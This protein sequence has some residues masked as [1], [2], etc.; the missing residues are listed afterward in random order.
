MIPERFVVEYPQRCME[1]LDMS[2]GLARER[3]LLGSFSLIMASSLLLIPYERMKKAHP[4]G[5]AVREPEIYSAIRSVERKRFLQTDFW[6]EVPPGEWR[7]SRILNDVNQTDR[8]QDA[9]R[10][11]PMDKDAVNGINDRDTGGIIRVLRNALAHGN[12]VYL[13]AEGFERRGAQVQYLAF[14]SRYEETEERREQGETYRLVATTE[15]GFIAFV[16]AWASWLCKLPYD[17][18][19]FADAAE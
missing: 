12:V 1:I 18:R 8:W 19:L 11:H 5:E 2:E 3:E 17:Q 7:Y 6:G 9:D 4:L 16:K 10:R 13:D 14:L 15:E